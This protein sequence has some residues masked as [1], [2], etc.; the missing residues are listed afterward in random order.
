MQ[1]IHAENA[2]MPA[3]RRRD[4]VAAGFGAAM[5]GPLGQGVF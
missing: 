5:S 1:S 3:G 2:S 4:R